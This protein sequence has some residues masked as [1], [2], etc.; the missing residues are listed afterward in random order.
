MPHDQFGR[1]ISVGDTVV[2]KGEVVKVLDDPNYLN[3][4]VRLAQQ[5]PPTGADTTLQLNT[6]QLEKTGGGGEE[7]GKEP[8]STPSSPPQAKPSEHKR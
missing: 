1:D 4:T 2:M 3:C 8:K 5:M 6:A 7:E